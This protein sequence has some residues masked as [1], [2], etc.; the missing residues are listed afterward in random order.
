MSQPTERPNGKCDH[1]PVWVGRI[2]LTACEECGRIDWLSEDGPVDHAE[3]MAA[4]FGSFDLIG[5]LDA[6][7]APSPKVLVYAPPSRGHRR[8]L[9]ALP[10]HAW[11]LAG[12][13]LWLS[14]DGEHL[15]LATSDVMLF[16]NMTRGA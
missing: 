1:R 14:H 3:A 8:H 10:A 15:L 6:L 11:L 16:D 12:P 9:E 4:V 2:A 13:H 5:C 7:G